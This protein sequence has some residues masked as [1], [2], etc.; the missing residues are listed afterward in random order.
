MVSF[1][2]VG[3]YIGF[4]MVVFAVESSNSWLKPAASSVLVPGRT[5]STSS[6]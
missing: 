3:I 2:T 5:S 6:R 4:Q 1:G